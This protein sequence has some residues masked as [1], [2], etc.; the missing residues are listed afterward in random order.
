MTN[1]EDSF[2]RINLTS[3]IKHIGRENMIKEDA[4]TQT[5]ALWSFLRNYS[6]KFWILLSIYLS[7]CQ[8]PVEEKNE[9]NQWKILIPK[10]TPN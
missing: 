4:D 7:I 2:N 5:W 8:G 9:N 10:E 3:I 1:N 6:L